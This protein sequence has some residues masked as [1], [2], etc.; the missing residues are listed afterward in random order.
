MAPRI[1]ISRISEPAKN[2]QTAENTANVIYPIS[3]QHIN[4]TRKPFESRIRTGREEEI[5]QDAL[6]KLKNNYY[7][8]YMISLRRQF[9]ELEDQYNKISKLIDITDSK[10]VSSGISK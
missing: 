4:I 10:D 1:R 8:T 6:R 5:I 3:T 2:Q 9:A 7:S